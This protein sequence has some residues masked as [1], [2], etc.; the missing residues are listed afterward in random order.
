MSVLKQR[1]SR[2]TFTGGV[3]AGA[4]AMAFAGRN[5]NVLAQDTVK[6]NL[7]IYQINDDW[8]NVLKGVIS[9]FATANPTIEVNLNIQPA[10]RRGPTGEHLVHVALVAG[11]PDQR[12]ARRIEDPVQG[13]GQLHHAEVRPEVP[14]GAYDGLHQPLAYLGG[15]RRELVGG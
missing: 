13:D 5:V 14:A 10:E 1:V 12:I 6:I 9:G 4:A 11:V 2:R 15:K 8:H 3:A 7:N